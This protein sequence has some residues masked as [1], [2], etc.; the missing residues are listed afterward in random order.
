MR[1]GAL[2][3]GLNL[4]HPRSGY[5]GTPRNLSNRFV[6]YPPQQIHRCTIRL[7]VVAVEHRAARQTERLGN[8]GQKFVRVWP[9]GLA[10]RAGYIRTALDPEATLHLAPELL[11]AQP[12][13]PPQ[14]SHTE[15]N[16][17]PC[18]TNLR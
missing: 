15:G 6:H 1:L 8:F 14:P 11:I 18:A 9:R 12:H 13:L 7:R 2:H 5:P 17:M 16:P 10:L 3:L 4:R